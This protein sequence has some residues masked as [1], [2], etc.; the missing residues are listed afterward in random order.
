VVLSCLVALSG[1]ALVGC[2]KKTD[3]S[4][5]AS[6]PQTGAGTA[7]NVTADV[8][9]PVAEVQ[10]QAQTMGVADLRAT[11]VQ[12][13]QAISVKKEDLQKVLAQVKELPLAEALSEKAKTLKAEAEK[14]QASLKDLTD[15]FQVYYNKLKEKGGNLSGLTI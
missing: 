8:E 15:R 7:V 9:K 6:A 14:I 10:T 12:Y 11:A 3:K 5:S 2:A 4:P 1:P 13:A